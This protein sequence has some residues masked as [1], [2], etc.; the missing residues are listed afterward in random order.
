MNAA[1]LF[2]GLQRLVRTTSRARL[3]MFV[4]YA[5]AGLGIVVLYAV[6]SR[7][8]ASLSMLGLAALCGIVTWRVVTKLQ[9]PQQPDTA[10]KSQRR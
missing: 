1:R 10:E 6:K 4:A 3:A 7:T 8:M 9:V 5:I 2:D